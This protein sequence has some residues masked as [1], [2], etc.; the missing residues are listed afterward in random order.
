MPGQWP[1]QCSVLTRVT[2]ST[3]R[4]RDRSRSPLQLPDLPC[5]PRA[6]PRLSRFPAL[7]RPRHSPPKLVQIVCV[8]LSEL[9]RQ[10]YDHFLDSKRVRSLLSKN[11]Q[12]LPAITLLKKLCN[13]P[14]LIREASSSQ[15]AGYDDCLSF[16]PPDYGRARDGC[17][18]DTSGKLL[19][20][21]RLL[22]KVCARPRGSS[23]SPGP[24][25]IL[26]TPPRPC[27]LPSAGTAPACLPGARRDRRPLR[28]REQLHVDA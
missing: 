1:L 10:L 18:A 23:A 9:Q 2:P 22:L 15:V 7:A 13:H 24:S 8:E 19:V 5:I 28:P 6:I 11:N 20:L 26:L 4:P 16:F 21:Q 17:R 27:P 25:A 12:A 3:S 14:L